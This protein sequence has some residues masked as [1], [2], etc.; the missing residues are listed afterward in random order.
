MSRR[1][2]NFKNNVRGWKASMH[3][4][5]FDPIDRNNP[6]VYD[7]DTFAP[8]QRDSDGVLRRITYEGS[9]QINIRAMSMTGYTVSY[10]GSSYTVPHINTY[11]LKQYTRD[12]LNN[13]ISLLTLWVDDEK[14]KLQINET[15]SQFDNHEVVNDEFNSDDDIFS[16]EDIDKFIQ[17]ITLTIEDMNVRDKIDGTLTYWKN[18]KRK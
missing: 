6:I 4:I 8:M 14:V 11:T 10:V 16:E 1:K 18:I 2:N 17:A 15:V 3:E 9:G 12:D 5:S 7:P 13:L